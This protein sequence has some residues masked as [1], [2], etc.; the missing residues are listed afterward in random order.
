[1]VKMVPLICPKCGA[2]IDV[3]EGMTSCFCTYCGTKISIG[4]DSTVTININHTT[5]DQV[6]LEKMRW[7]HQMWEEYKKESPKQLRKCLIALLVCFGLLALC[8]FLAYY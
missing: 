1:M 2:S 5:T 4:D 8:C 6:K 7:E 3:K